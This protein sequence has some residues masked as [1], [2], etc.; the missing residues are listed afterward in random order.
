[1]CL[2]Q[3]VKRNCGDLSVRFIPTCKNKYKMMMDGVYILTNLFFLYSSSS[4]FRLLSFSA[5]VGLGLMSD[6]WCLYA[7]EIVQ[8][9]I[10]FKQTLILLTNYYTQTHTIWAK[11]NGSTSK[12]ITKT[13]LW[14]F[15]L[16]PSAA[17]NE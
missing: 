3:R 7:V 8:E 10:F 11:Q 15:S 16:H 9:E 4:S 13:T 14:A 6:V 17:M 2:M 1:M 5:T 12:N